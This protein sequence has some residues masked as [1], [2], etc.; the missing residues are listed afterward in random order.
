MSNKSFTSCLSCKVFFPCF[1]GNKF[2]LINSVLFSEKF[3]KL[4]GILIS[5][6]FAVTIPLGVSIT[7]INYHS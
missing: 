1:V 3:T 2:I 7:E 6:L 5:Q 4:F